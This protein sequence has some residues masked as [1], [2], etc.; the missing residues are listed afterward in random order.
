MTTSEIFTMGKDSIALITG[1]LSAT[2]IT[3]VRFILEQARHSE[4]SADFLTKVNL[5]SNGDG[6]ILWDFN[7][8]I[9]KK[10]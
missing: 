3:D 7:L 4:S 9:N 5:I 1:P 10:V 8:I 6:I 2:D